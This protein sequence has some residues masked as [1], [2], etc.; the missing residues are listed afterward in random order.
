MSSIHQ[1]MRVALVSTLALACHPDRTVRADYRVDL[2]EAKSGEAV[3]TLHLS[4]APPSL[5]LSSLL[6]DDLLGISGFRIEDGGGRPVQFK[7][8]PPPAGTKRSSRFVADTGGSDELTV[9]YRVRAAPYW[10]RSGAQ[11]LRQSGVLGAGG[12][13]FALPGLL[14]LPS[15]MPAEVGFSLA[16]PDAWS[17]VEA[18]GATVLTSELWRTALVAG[19]YRVRRQPLA[20]KVELSVFAGAPADAETVVKRVV[21]ELERALGEPAAPLHVILAPSAKDDLPAELPGQLH[22][23]IVDLRDDDPESL[24]S[25]VHAIATRWHAR[26]PAEI[27]G[28]S[29]PGSW[30]ELGLTEYLALTVPVELGLV[31]RDV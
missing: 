30:F 9:R 3:V 5:E 2:G 22:T 10:P 20:A 6:V 26:T 24:R 16:L 14:L 12:A 27:E 29:S 28:D 31:Q 11:E 4:G 21:E 13:A 1:V 17:V 19:D 7:T 25:L 8:V 18:P 15:E 23:A